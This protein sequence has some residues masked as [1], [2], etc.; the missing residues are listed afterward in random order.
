VEW[1]FS[2]SGS[3]GEFSPA[4][5]DNS[6]QVQIADSRPTKAASLFIPRQK[7][8]LLAAVCVSDKDRSA[9]EFSCKTAGGA[10]QAQWRL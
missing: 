3:L 5:R 6:P 2:Y 10:M 4:C 9:L 1:V 8:P 7:T